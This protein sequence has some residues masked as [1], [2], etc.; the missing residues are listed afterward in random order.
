MRRNAYAAIGCAALLCAATAATAQTAPQDPGAPAAIEYADARHIV[1]PGEETSAPV[2]ACDAIAS[3]D[4]AIDCL[5]RAR[6]A[7]DAGA[8]DM[9]VA[10]RRD[11]GVVV[12]S[13]APH[14][15]NGGFRGQ[16]QIVGAVPV[17]RDRQHLDWLNTAL[18]D[19]NWFV[20]QLRGHAA[21][22]MA[23]YAQP[24]AVRFMR[25]VRR[26]T[27]SAYA[28]DW[29]FSYNVSGSLM[30]TADGVR[31]TLF[32]EIFHLNDEAHTSGSGRRW[33]E[34]I[35]SSIS[36]RIIQGCGTRRSCLRAYAP[37]T[38]TVRGGTYY[39][40]QQNNGSSVVE[41]AAELALRYYQEQRAALRH[42]PFPRGRFKCGPSEN[43]RAWELLRDEFFGG[44]DLVA[45]CE[46]P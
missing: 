5:V 3:R 26:T 30:R 27:P 17:G 43:A 23:Y 12:G 1:F 21:R 28:L 20:S 42:E 22:P 32:H 41:Y 31:E 2:R 7:S 25:S 13:E 14:T 11:L 4:A 24:R 37:S 34:R 33:S 29:R 46:T 6:F 8:A 15:M 9:A 40:F 39:A 10:L 36:D 38:T 16:I 18:R 19:F 45:A 35:L 44:A